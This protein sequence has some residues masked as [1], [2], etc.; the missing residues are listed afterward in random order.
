MAMVRNL[1]GMSG[2]VQARRWSG[3]L[4]EGRRDEGGVFVDRAA[5]DVSGVFAERAS[6]RL[7]LQGSW[8]QK[9]AALGGGLA[10]SRG[11]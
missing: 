8:R 10:P 7:R 3:L 9:L 5:V 4:T 11:W 1:W 2:E 6:P